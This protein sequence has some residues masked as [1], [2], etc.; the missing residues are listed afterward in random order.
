MYIKMF[1][2]KTKIGI[3]RMVS[4][5]TLHLMIYSNIAIK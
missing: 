2:C 4:C 1:T 5:R 3:S